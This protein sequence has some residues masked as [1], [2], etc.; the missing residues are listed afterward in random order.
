[1]SFER[2]LRWALVSIAIVGLAAGIL[3]LEQEI[4]PGKIEIIAG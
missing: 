2:V 3:A 4:I 1:M